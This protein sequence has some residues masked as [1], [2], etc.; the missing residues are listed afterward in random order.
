MR[1]KQVYYG[2]YIALALA[3]TETISYGVICYSFSVFLTS[4][5]A[6]LAWTRTEITGRFSLALMISGLMAYPVGWWVDRHGARGLMSAGAVGA[7]ALLIALS[8]VQTLPMYYLIWVGLGVCAEMLWYEPAFTV[9]AVWFRER[10]SQAMAIVTFTAGLASTIFLP[11]A[12]YLLTQLGWRG[13]T[14][15]LA[16]LL[17]AVNL[18]LH[19]LILRRRPSDLGLLPEG[20][21]LP[22]DR[23]LP[24]AHTHG[25]SVRDALRTPTYW[26]ILLAFGLAGSAMSATRVHFIPLLVANGTNATAAASIAGLI[27]LMQ[28]AGRVIYTPL[29]RRFAFQRMA[30]IVFGM[31]MVSVV[32]LLAGTSMVWVF[33]FVG[34]Y[35]MAV[36]AI[37]LVRPSFLAELYG[38]AHYGQI[39][40]IQSALLTPLTTLAPVGAGWLFDHF[41]NYQGMLWISLGFSAA[42]TLTLLF[43][44]P[45]PLNPAPIG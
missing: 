24:P 14:F 26:Q 45:R 29:E 34:L 38:S 15:A 19:A 5:E 10:R 9:L 21:A 43:M 39:S 18:P 20:H 16:L 35:G 17:G 2:W 11:L 8:R 25:M 13:A 30:I 28:V 6:E 33:A 32:M 36:G 40:S 37:T 42:A 27:G 1:L 41:Q 3:I 44:H 12:T 23:T 22:V 31:L 4:M 7:T